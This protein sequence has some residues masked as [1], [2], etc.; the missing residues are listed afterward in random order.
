[1]IG[2][3]LRV[4][5]WRR[6]RRNSRVG[7]ATLKWDPLGLLV[8]RVV[9]QESHGTLWVTLPAAPLL[10]GSEQPLRDERGKIVHVPLATFADDAAKAAFRDVVLA[11]VKGLDPTAFDAE[12]RP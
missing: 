8:Q 12:D 1:M 11:G 5:Q 3:S 10:D 2:D 6:D 7:Y 9:V 4:V